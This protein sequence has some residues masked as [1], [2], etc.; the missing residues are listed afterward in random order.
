MPGSRKGSKVSAATVNKELRTI[1]AVLRMAA[2][3]EYTLRVPKITFEKEKKYD[4][5]FVSSDEFSKFYDACKVATMPRDLA[6]DPAD[7]WRA[8][9]LF[10]YMTGWRIS[11]VMAFR[12]VDLIKDGETL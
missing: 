5:T 2:D 6:C 4:P 11:E 7:W 1:K 12:K 9:L 8:L 3:W 10:Q